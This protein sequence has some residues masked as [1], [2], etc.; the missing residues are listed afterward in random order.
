MPLTRL[1]AVGA[2][3]LSDWP[4]PRTNPTLKRCCAALALRNI[5]VFSGNGPVIHNRNELCHKK[6]RTVLCD[7]HQQLPPAPAPISPS[8]S[9]IS[10]N[11]AH[12]LQ[13]I[14]VHSLAHM[15][16]RCVTLTPS[17]AY[18]SKCQVQARQCDGKT[19]K[20]HLSR[21]WSGI[22]GCFCSKCCRLN[23]RWKSAVCAMKPDTS[24]PRQQRQR[25]RNRKFQGQNE[26]N[27]ASR[28]R[29]QMTGR[30]HIRAARRRCWR[31][32]SHVVYQ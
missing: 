1:S 24:S 10:R 9:Q 12:A 32:F 29:L 31:C 19:C 28:T 5:S 18:S 22:A 17:L 6:Q 13:P 25:T 16:T 21:K 26:N 7:H 23:L 3:H 27:S 20:A 15:H 30:I 4:S 11:T 8:S 2:Q 14:A